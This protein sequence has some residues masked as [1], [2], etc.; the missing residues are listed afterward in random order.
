ML[1][2]LLLTKNLSYA[3]T[4][5]YALLA[6][7]LF[8]ISDAFAKY[9]MT[10]GYDRST[11]I[12]TTSLP[13]FIVLSISMYLRRGSWQHI[14][15][16]PYKKLHIMR[17]LALIS[18]TY[19][20]FKSVEVLPLTSFYG[21]IFSAP[22]I[23]TIF[24]YFAFKE[25]TPFIE[26]VMIA[27]GFA[28]VL[29]VVNPDF[30]NFNIAYL[31]A[32]GAVVSVSTAGIIVR[33]IGRE[34]DPFLFVIFGSAALIIANIIPAFRHALPETV[35]IMHI[36]IMTIYA[37]TIPTAILMM[38]A[39]FARAPAVSAI[40]P[41]QYSQ[42]IWGAIIGYLVFEDVPTLNVVV[43]SGIVIACGLYLI[44][45]HKR[46]R[47]RELRSPDYATDT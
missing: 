33:K 3:Q 47:R 28:G 21:I 37:I 6:Y 41:Y 43:G 11:I 25:K 2:S 16:T 40:V 4:A 24:A 13:S 36:F 45:H 42:I 14:Y 26:W 46:K 19:F 15:Q 22:F 18:I 20:M 38:S 34:E 1:K 7:F 39:V 44:F 17:G 8:S 5:F 27:I 12:V 29:I 10:E 32:L 35:T 31:Y 9:F 30:D 23:T